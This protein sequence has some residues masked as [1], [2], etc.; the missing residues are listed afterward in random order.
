MAKR[1][2]KK[3]RKVSVN[4]EGVQVS[5]NI[6]EA[7]Y[8]GKPDS[9]TLETSDSS[10]N[11]YLD[12]EFVLTRGKYKGRKF[13]YNT[14]LQPQALWNLRGVLEAL[15]QEVPESA[16]DIDLDELENIQ[17]E[18]GLSIE[19]DEY[20]GK[21][22]SKIMDV[23]HLDMVEDDQGED[24]MSGKPSEKDIKKMDED[25]LE[26]VVDEHELDVDLD[27][28]K[29]IKKKRAAVIEALE[30][31]G[32]DDDGDDVEGWELPDVSDMDEDDLE[33]VIEEHDLE[34][35]LDDY[36]TIKKKRK[37]VAEALEEAGGDD[38]GDGDEGYD[39]DDV[40]KMKAKELKA[41]VE[42]H[43]LKVKIPAGKAN[44]KTRKKVV[45]ALDKADLLD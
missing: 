11:D 13:H 35:D 19:L 5:R 17:D 23:I 15:N 30:E 37:A 31:S 44:D 4:M 22:R 34:V 14:S 42:K 45:E 24:G 38:D 43:G 32:G 26:E 18:C 28:I 29:G 2:K 39:E 8:I 21:K 33:E 20:E 16:M 3:G 12:W 41:L 7:D 1:R 40:M 6:P 10:G 25:E 9:V 27:E 36:K